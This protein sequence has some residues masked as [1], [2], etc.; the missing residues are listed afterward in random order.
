MLAVTE[1]IEA[2][3]RAAEIDHDKEE[4]RE[5]VQAEMCAE[6]WKADGESQTFGRSLAQQLHE[7]DDDARARD[8]QGGA[9]DDHASGGAVMQEKRKS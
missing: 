4:R 3:G 6:P 5:R 9:V 7:R 8:E 2:R 1:R